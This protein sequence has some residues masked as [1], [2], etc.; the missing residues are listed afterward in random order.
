M[1]AS[2]SKEGI[3]ADLEAMKSAG[4][5]GAYLVTIKGPADPP[6]LAP[7]IQ[8]LSP[9]WWAMV[10][11][12]LSEADRLGLKIGMHASDGFAVAGGPWITPEN[13]MQKV[14][15][16]EVTH[17]GGRGNGM[18][19]LPKPESFPGYYRDIA[20]LAFPNTVAT[21]ANK[22]IPAITTSKPGEDAGFLNNKDNNQNYR[23]EDPCWI[24][25]AFSRPFTCRS[26]TIKTNGPN[27]QA[28]RLIVEVSDDEK[29]FRS[30]GR[31]TPPRHGWQDNDAAV[32]HAIVPTTARVFRFRFDRS[33][34]EPGAEDLD[35]AK[36]K[37]TLKIS[38]I[39]LSSTPKIHQFEGK[40]G[41]VWRVSTRTTTQQV[42]DAIC[43][44]HESIVDLTEYIDANDNLTWN[45]PKGDWTI[46]RIGHTST[47]HTNYT[48]GAGK[49]LE[50]DKFNPDAVKIQFNNWFGEAVRKAGEEPTAHSLKMFY[51]DSW[52]CGSQN[53]SL[54]FPDEFK[55]RRGY[56]LKT[57][58]PVMAG[59]PIASADVSE[60]FLHDVRQ[61]I[62][63]LVHDKFYGTLNT[64]AH[65]LNYEFT[66]ES[67]APTMTSDG[68]LHYNA[69]DI[70]MGEFWFRSPTH[71][72]PNDLLDA[73]SAAHI[74]GK[75][76]IQAEGFTQLRMSWDEH[77]AVLKTLAD[78]VFCM[79]VN[80]LV[81]H[82]FTHNPWLDRKPGMT[83]DGVGHYFQRDQTWWKPGRAWVAYAERCQAL[84]QQGIP[85]VDIAVFTGEELPRRAVLPDRLVTTLPGIFGKGVV[86]REAIRLANKGEPLRELPEG[87][88]HAQNMADPEHWLD[89][90]NGYKYDS[91]N[92]DALLR[93]AAVKKGRIVL[94][95]GASYA[96]LLIPGTHA[97]QP[98]GN[99]MSPEVITRLWELVNDGATIL[100]TEKPERA[101]GLSESQRSDATVRSIS[102]KLFGGPFKLNNEGVAV[103]HVGK[104]RVIK[105]PYHAESFKSVGLD[106]DV[107]ITDSTQ[108]KLSGMAWTH[109]VTQDHEIYFFSNQVNKDRN[110]TVSLRSSG[111][112][113]ILYDAV[114]NDVFVPSK[115]EV[116]NARTQVTFNI[117]A[118]GSKFVLLRPKT[119]STTLAYH[120]IDSNLKQ[121][122]TLSGDWSVTFDSTLGGPE[123]TNIFLSLT[124]W[125][126]HKDP[127]I[128]YYSGTAKYFKMFQW[129][130]ATYDGRV[131]LDLGRVENIA[132]VF[133]NGISYGVAWTP[134]YRVE[135]TKALKNGENELTIE[136]TNTWANRLI[137]DYHLPGEK[138]ITNTTAPYRL[139]G[140]SL[141]PAGLLGPV[142]IKVSAEAKSIDKTPDGTNSVK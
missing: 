106:R 6:L 43:I 60:R 67:V 58:L 39:E 15:W 100:F 54:A 133:V 101:P 109:R 64:L 75:P 125:I 127:A 128:Q 25:Y 29:S 115:S 1:H 77:P 11:H 124:D 104:G 7:P 86:E 36:W 46:L 82:V 94:P 141:L 96:M 4:I 65:E 120:K 45:A 37:P 138:R 74:Y 81:Y 66:A 31:L 13:S 51:I 113:A 114:G 22:D 89:A 2:I 129:K 110:V 55:K 69:V 10:K 121:T 99:L 38:G 116:V 53:W 118:N 137:G 24:Q 34:S 40:N 92:K 23:S 103:R 97:M 90:L 87:V 126:A 130:P 47:G 78:R 79:G 57:Y 134:P 122:Q 9:E 48:G 111:K 140:K 61:T 27:Y 30:L 32:T 12:A 28:H 112:E 49:G 85:V 42:P 71:D 3:T 76:I 16:S 108:L 62:T 132:E 105:G 72:K 17:R 50:C 59:Y 21:Q 56:D 95:G 14:V 70:P 131:F 52:E 107:I 98:Q 119:K 68:M 139:A 91:F 63:E 20:V 80:R 136:V 88:S 73:I 41:T 8:Q 19:Y 33:G 5:G 35:A 142:T 93:L 83:L 117:A 123:G 135:I 102:D 26:I 84:L 18:I 44:K